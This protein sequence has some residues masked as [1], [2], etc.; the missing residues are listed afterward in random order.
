MAFG[1]QLQKDFSILIYN[2]YMYY[3]ILIMR[4]FLVK[5]FTISVKWLVTF[6]ANKMEMYF[7]PLLTPCSLLLVPASVP[8]LV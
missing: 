2:M 1:Y 4:P 7:I 8:R 6:V 3:V 5:L